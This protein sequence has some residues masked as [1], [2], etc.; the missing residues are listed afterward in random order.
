M[1]DS[2]IISMAL[3]VVGYVVFKA[4]RFTRESV[5]KSNQRKQDGKYE[6]KQRSYR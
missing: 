5:I 6:I 1:A 2:F 4:G 3:I